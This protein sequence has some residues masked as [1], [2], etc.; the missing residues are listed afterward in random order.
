MER[1]IRSILTN[2]LPDVSAK[3][4][5]WGIKPQSTP[6]PA[7]VINVISGR[8]YATFERPCGLFQ[9]RIQVDVFGTDYA[10]TLSLSKRVRSVLDGYKDLSFQ[11]IFCETASSAAE[12]GANESQPIYRFRYDFFVNYVEAKSN[13]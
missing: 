13:E 8:E 12:T 5:N 3:Q 10:E 4:I 1:A 9:G 11:G 7:V 2:G 6:F